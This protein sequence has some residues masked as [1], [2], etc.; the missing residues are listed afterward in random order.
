MNGGFRDLSIAVLL[1]IAR[2]SESRRSREVREARL[3]G[4][5][6]PMVK[7]SAGRGQITRQLIWWE[8]RAEIRSGGGRR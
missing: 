8:L 6:R 7:E 5:G 3:E 1:D 4:S 2:A